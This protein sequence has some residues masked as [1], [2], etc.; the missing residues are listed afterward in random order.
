[1]KSEQTRSRLMQEKESAIEGLELSETI[2][3]TKK[4]NQNMKYRNSYSVQKLPSRVMTDEEQS[5]EENKSL[6]S[7][8]SFSL[9]E[10]SVNQVRCVTR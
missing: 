1:M 7:V 2:V 8:S 3:A 10:E 4:R 5:V 9:T 6:S